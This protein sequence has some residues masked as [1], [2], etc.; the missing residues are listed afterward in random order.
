MTVRLAE[1]AERILGPLAGR[2]DAAWYRAPAGKWSPAQI[3]EHLAISM[4]GSAELFERR[5]AHDPMTRRPRTLFE[6]VG[7]WFVMAVGFYP[8]GF[9]APEGTIPAPNVTRGAAEAK[10][11]AGLAH[12]EEL[13]R[14]L[15]PARRYD[16]FVKHP[17]FGDLTVEEWM[18]FHVVHARHHEKQIHARLAG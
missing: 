5:R 10:F 16:L 14:L 9:R 4:V 1:I 17:R 11:R 8:Q 18:R 15:L 6:R 2:P 13:P 12:W 3:V 7:G